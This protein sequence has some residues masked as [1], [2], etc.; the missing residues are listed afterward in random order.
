MSGVFQSRMMFR[1]LR[2]GILAG[3]ERFPGEVLLLPVVRSKK[4]V[5]K[6]Q[7]IESAVLEVVQ[8]EDVSQGF[9]HLLPVDHEEFRMEPEIRESGAVCSFALRDFVFMMDRDVVHAAAVDIERLP[10]PLSRH[11]GAFYVPAWEPDAPLGFPIP[12]A[13]SDPWAKI[14]TARSPSGA[15]FPDLPDAGTF[16]FSSSAWPGLQ[17]AV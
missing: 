5:S 9:R 14:S 16:S 17:R 6:T 10:E 12:S 11:G 7:R 2:E 8:G 1:E 13:A 4:E 15:S 3:L